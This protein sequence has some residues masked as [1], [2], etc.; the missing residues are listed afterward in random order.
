[1]DFIRC[2]EENVL[3]S[4]HFA[5]ISPAIERS[6]HCEIRETRL[7][8]IDELDCSNDQ[9]SNASQVEG[10]GITQR[11]L[12]LRS[13]PPRSTPKTI[14]EGSGVGGSGLEGSGE[15]IHSIFCCVHLLVFYLFRYC[16]DFLSHPQR[17]DETFLSDTNSCRSRA[18]A[19]HLLC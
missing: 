14:V 18:L 8:R 15:V 2:I 16:C 4:S 17:N 9:T 13:L 7:N 19:L 5:Y 12:E 6:A 10:S 1:M 11:P 3:S